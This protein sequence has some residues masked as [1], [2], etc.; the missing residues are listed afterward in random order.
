MKIEFYRS[1][2]TEERAMDYSET[3]VET[4]GLQSFLKFQPLPM[5]KPLF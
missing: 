3:S 2:A 5:F 4:F 1:S